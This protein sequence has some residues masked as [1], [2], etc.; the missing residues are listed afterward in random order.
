MSALDQKQTCAMQNVMS[1]S[2]PKADMCS[3]KRNVRLPIA[4]I[5]TLNAKGHP[6]GR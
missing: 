5:V 2:C 1:H 6:F 3:A 4:D